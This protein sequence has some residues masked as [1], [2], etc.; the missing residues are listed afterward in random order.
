MLKNI[1]NCPFYPVLPNIEKYCPLLF[2]WLFQLIFVWVVS[3]DNVHN[4]QIL[5][6][7]VKCGLILSLLIMS[8]FT[9]IVQWHPMWTF[10]HYIYDFYI[11]YL[12]LDYCYLLLAICYMLYDAFF[13]KLAITCKKLFPFACCCTSRNFFNTPLRGGLGL[14]S[15][16]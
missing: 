3:C 11:Q 16:L 6:N 13:L 8:S 7:I 10:S 4:I 15:K 1:Y 5:S 2:K 9:D 14:K 12:L